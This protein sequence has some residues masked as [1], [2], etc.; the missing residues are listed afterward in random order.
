MAKPTRQFRA[1]DGVTWL[2]QVQNPGASN[3]MVIFTAGRERRYAH[4]LETS[5]AAMNVST[6]VDPED[7]LARLDDGRL[8]QLLRRS[9]S[10]SAGKTP[11]DN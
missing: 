1:A 5:A 8:T 9:M 2:V 4:W 7:V 10:V 11:L 3:A 6:R